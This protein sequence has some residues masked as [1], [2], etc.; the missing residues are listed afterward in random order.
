MAPVQD[1]NTHSLVQDVR[2]RAGD[3]LGPVLDASTLVGGFVLL[4]LAARLLVSLV[5]GK[6]PNQ[7]PNQTSKREAGGHE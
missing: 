4:L 6:H 1:F 3:W 5:Q 7:T 2:A